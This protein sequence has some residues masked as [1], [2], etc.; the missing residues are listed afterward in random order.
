MVDLPRL[1]GKLGAKRVEVTADGRER[2]STG[3]AK[4]N[5][6]TSNNAYFCSAKRGIF[7]SESR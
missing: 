6:A 5:Y 4:V 2:D 1:H 7:K 3:E